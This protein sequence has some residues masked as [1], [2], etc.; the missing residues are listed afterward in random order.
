MKEPTEVLASA[1]PA[2]IICTRDRARAVVF[3]RETL[4]LALDHEDRLAAVF[5]IGGVTLRVSTVA[6]FE[7]HEHTILG[8]RVE[9]VEATVKALRDKG[10]TFN[11]YPGFP[12]NE[13]GILNLPE[14]NVQVA[15]FKDPDGNVLSVA[16]V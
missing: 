11:F 15:W 1:E 5:K 9:N 8:F 3:Y 16:N 13:L 12:Q 10:I 2:I 4:G 14:E 7:P 6:N